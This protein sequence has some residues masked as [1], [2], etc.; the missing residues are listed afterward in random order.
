M[1]L[2]SQ[3]ILKKVFGYPEFKGQQEAIIEA[4]LQGRDSLVIMPT[5]G[6]KSLCYQIPAM[7]REGTGLVVSP[8]IALMQDQVTALHE[9]GIA[10]EFLNSSQSLD[11]R[12]DVT[13]KLRQGRLQ[14]LYIAPERLAT[15]QTRSL[16]R[17][18]PLSMIAIDEAHCVS[19]W[20]H[21]FRHDYLTLGEL[22]ALFPGVPRMAVTIRS[23]KY[24]LCGASE[25]RRSTAAI[26]IFPGASRRSR[27]C[28][29]PVAQKN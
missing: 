26:E 27:N 10:A 5:G 22:G 12:R 24:Q 23:A 2:S 1:S 29:L 4:A 11:E 15:E 17:D 16:L 19:Q 6:G 13:S 8:L 25:R 9:L 28:L 18:I 14:L 20:G 21:D 3:N 7:L